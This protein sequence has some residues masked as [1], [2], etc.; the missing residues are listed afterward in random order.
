MD[1]HTI[2][3]VRP[4]SQPFGHPFVAPP[5]QA[6]IPYASQRTGQTLHGPRVLLGGRAS[7]GMA[8]ASRA[9]RQQG[10]LDPFAS[11]T[12]SPL[13][14]KGRQGAGGATRHVLVASLGGHR[15]LDRY[16]RFGVPRS[17]GAFGFPGVQITS[18]AAQGLLQ[19]E[20]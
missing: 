4:L 10:Q 7:P 5:S 8:L 6:L 18:A 9:I 1:T 11:Y 16:G 17:F 13:S 20:D 3:P 15:R 2:H 19:L 14:R 12:L